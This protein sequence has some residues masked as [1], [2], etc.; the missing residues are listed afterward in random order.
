MT[1]GYIDGIDGVFYFQAEAM[2]KTGDLITEDTPHELQ[3]KTTY[4]VEHCVPYYQR[5]ELVGLTVH[6]KKL[7]PIS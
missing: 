7:D 1:E 4:R 3:D 2:L 5:N 6:C